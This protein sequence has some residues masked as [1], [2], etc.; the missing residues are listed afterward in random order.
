MLVKLY[1]ARVRV[2]HYKIPRVDYPLWW[3]STQMETFLSA[4]YWHK[5]YC[6]PWLRSIWSSLKSVR[7][8]QT[9]NSLRGLRWRA[10]LHKQDL[11]RDMRSRL[12]DDYSRGYSQ[13]YGEGTSQAF[14]H[15]VDKE[16]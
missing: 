7:H 15:A 10:L 11:A 4:L 2:E 3:E 8:E 9:R 5:K 14:S 13:G 12:K 1:K 6:D 16:T